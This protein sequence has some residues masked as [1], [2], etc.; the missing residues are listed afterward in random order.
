MMYIQYYL[1]VYIHIVTYVFAEEKALEGYGY[2]GISLGE[3][4][5]ITVMRGNDSETRLPEFKP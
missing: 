2:S 1:T 4:G 5:K 3:Q